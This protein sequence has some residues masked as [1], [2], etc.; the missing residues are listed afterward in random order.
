MA[1]NARFFFVLLSVSAAIGIGNMFL[2]PYFSFRLGGLFFIPYLIALAIIGVPMLLLEFSAGQQFNKNVVDIFASVRKWLSGIGWFMVLNSFLAMGIYAVILSWHV[3]YIFVS[4]GIQ[5]KNDAGAYF[6]HNVLQSSAG[7][8]GFLRLSLPVFLALVIA[9]ILIFICIRNGF[10]SIKKSFLLLSAC[11][12]AM[13]IFFMAYSLTLDNGLSGAYLFLK[14]DVRGMLSLNVW[15]AAF[16]LAIS[17]IGVS[18]GVMHALSRR[19]RC[20]FLVGSSF[21][22]AFLELVVSLAFGFVFFSI[23]GFLSSKKGVAAANLA[24]SDYGST[25]TVLAEAFQHFHKPVL[26]SILAF[27]FFSIFILIAVASLAYAI[28]HVI[29]E[30]L[31]TGKRNAAILVAGFGFLYGLVFTVKPGIY[32]MDI[33][34][35][36]IYY[37]ILIAVLLECLALGWAYEPRKISDYIDSRSSIKIGKASMFIIRYIVP[38][39]AL[40]LLLLQIIADLSKSYNN[41]PLWALLVFGAGTVIFPAL[42]AFLMPQKLLDRR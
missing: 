20:G 21:I 36:F 19:S 26:L 38:V 42:A 18:F 25:F 13:L 23:L 27:A 11:L 17:S 5:W 24:Y 10:E 15:V 16:S 12:A 34:S 2:F 39:I 14:P 9:W 3:I 30:K 8:S 33:V 32:I 31:D 7:L 35:H 4:F 37:N 29:K 6:L 40:A 22:A 41:Y 28:M 1:S